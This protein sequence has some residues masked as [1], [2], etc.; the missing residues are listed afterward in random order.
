MRPLL[1][2][3]S[4]SKTIAVNA[5]ESNR[6]M[7][8]SCVTITFECRRMWLTSKSRSLEQFTSKHSQERKST[9]ELAHGFPERRL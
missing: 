9:T 2:G 5:R 3:L 1:L 8:E 6:L 4:A 7:Y